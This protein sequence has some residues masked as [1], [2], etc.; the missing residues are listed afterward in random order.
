MNQGRIEEE[1]P[2]EELFRKPK[3]QRLAEFLK[4]SKF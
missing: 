1:G 2:P 3:S 4:N